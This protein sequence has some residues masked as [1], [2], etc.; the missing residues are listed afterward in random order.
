MCVHLVSLVAV[1]VDQKRVSDP[2]DWSRIVSCRA[3]VLAPQSCLLMHTIA[4]V[5]L[6]KDLR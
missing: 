5:G 4:L 6:V 3:T 2:R 1:A